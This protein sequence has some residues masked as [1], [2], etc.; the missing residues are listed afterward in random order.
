MADAHRPQLTPRQVSVL[1]KLLRAGFRFLT[2]ERMERYLAVEK[3]GFIAL[4][5]PGGGKIRIFG[6]AGYRIGEGIGMLVERAEGKA[7]VWHGES[8][9]ASPELLAAYNRFKTELKE[10][11]EGEVQEAEGNRE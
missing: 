3:E 6:Q 8:V 7:F 5:D 1:E 4:L 2:L 9:A 11:L 10:L